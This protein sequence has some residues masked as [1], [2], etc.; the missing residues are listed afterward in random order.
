MASLRD[1]ARWRNWAGN[2]VCAPTAIHQ[3]S[4]EGE[5]VAIVQRAA[6]EGRRVRCVGAGHSFTGLVCTDGDLIDLSR[7]A[8]VLAV[9][10]AA[11]LAT[12]QAGIPL[13]RLSRELAT[14]GLALENLGD[15]AYQSVA[16]ATATATHGT[17][18][19]F[20]NLSSAIV[21]MRL[22]DGHGRVHDVSPDGDAA[23]LV[24]I[25]PVGLGALGVVS[26]VTIRCVPSFNLHAVEQAEPIDEVLERFDDEA[27]G[28]DHFELFWVPGT[29][30]SLTKRNT[31]TQEPVRPLPT[32]RRWRDDIVYDNLAFGV[33]QKV[34]RHRNDLVPAVARR[35]PST[36]RR[37]YVDASYEVFAS[38][39]LVRFHEMEY[40]VPR[41]AGVAA[42]G[43]V[44]RLV[45]RL[46]YH[47]GFPVEV[48][49]VA[50]DDLALST[51][52]GRD[53]VYIACHVHRG[54]PQDAYFRGVE[55]IMDAHD[56]RPH[57]G[58][59]HFQTA[60][61]LAPRYPRWDDFAAA[62][63]RLDPAGTFA[64]P[65]LDRVLGPIGG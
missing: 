7:Y 49:V 26:T 60:A 44:R 10:R 42:L 30:W 24:D 20:R 57:W 14:H 17:G 23:D 47:V 51:A 19:R 41:D 52:S 4:S 12:V 29:R 62:R 54:V 22:V 33:L 59:L 38:P 18:A 3:P 16:G 34:A 13:H 27:D 1:R 48:R 31:R 45:D 53:T 63:A 11:G 61:T 55:S 37:D 9:D 15:I 58:K 50:A 21:A 56:G 2:Q 40:A 36:G 65:A 32:W 28:T 35:L 8:E 5:I 39:R 46:G 64:N 43:E 6:A 25:A